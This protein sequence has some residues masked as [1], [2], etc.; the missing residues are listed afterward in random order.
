MQITFSAEDPIENVLAMIQEVYGVRVKV[1]DEDRTTGAGPRDGGRSKQDR[2]RHADED[3]SKQD[4]TSLDTER[5]KQDR[6]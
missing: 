6:T 5:S 1:A 3:R 4:R 2:T